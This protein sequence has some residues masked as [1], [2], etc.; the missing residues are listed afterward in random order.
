MFKKTKYYELPGG[1]K[2]PGPGLTIENGL[3]GTGCNGLNSG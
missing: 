1:P 3:V 2:G